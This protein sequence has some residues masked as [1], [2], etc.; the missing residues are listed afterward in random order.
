MTKEEI[1][2]IITLLQASLTEKKEGEKSPPKTK[3]TKD[4]RSIR[5]NPFTPEI[6]KLIEE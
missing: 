5:E 3:E 4:E 1:E 2:K 6:N